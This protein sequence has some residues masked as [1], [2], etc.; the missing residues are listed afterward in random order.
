MRVEWGEATGEPALLMDPQ[1]VWVPLVGGEVCGVLAHRGVVA[2]EHVRFFVRVDAGDGEEWLESAVI[3]RN[4]LGSDNGLLAAL[5]A[6]E[7]TRTITSPAVRR[8]M[9][10]ADFWEFETKQ[11]WTVRILA[12]C[13]SLEGPH[14]VFSTRVQ[15][16]SDGVWP[17]VLPTL[18]F[19]VSLMPSD[20]EDRV[21]R[22]W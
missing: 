8:L 21:T 1:L 3:A 18:R 10:P 14:L 20:I 5:F 17:V 2:D 11:G 12:S 15:I 13:C 19:P 4:A 6:G 9:D 16:G 22:N 7:C